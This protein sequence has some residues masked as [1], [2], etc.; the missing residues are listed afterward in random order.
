MLAWLSFLSSGANSAGRQRISDLVELD[1]MV[2]MPEAL[3]A[4]DSGRA[5]RLVVPSVAVALCLASR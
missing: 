4:G 5:V 1:R 2:Q 3:F